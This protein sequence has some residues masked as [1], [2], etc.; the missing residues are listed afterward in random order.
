MVIY[1]LNQM[2]PGRQIIKAMIVTNRLLLKTELINPLIQKY[3]ITTT[4]TTITIITVQGFV[5]FTGHTGDLITFPPVIQT[6]TSTMI[7]TVPV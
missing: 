5:G 4:T 3:I 2:R 6:G 7:S 1:G